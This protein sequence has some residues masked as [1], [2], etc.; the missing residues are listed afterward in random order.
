MVAYLLELIQVMQKEVM[1][2]I[3]KLVKYK[4]LSVNLKTKKMKELEDEIKKSTL[5]LTNQSAQVVKKCFTKLQRMKNIN[6]TI[7]IKNNTNKFGKELR[8]MYCLG[9]YRLYS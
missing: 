8:T 4:H 5:Q 9:V 3:M 1:I 7:K 6:K 2:Q